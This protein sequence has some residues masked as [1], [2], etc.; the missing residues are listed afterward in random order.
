VTGSTGPQADP[1]GP[2]ATADDAGGGGGGGYP[3][4]GAGGLT[5]GG[6]GGAGIGPT[7]GVG[8][9]GSAGLVTITY[10]VTDTDQCSADGGS[11]VAEPPAGAETK[12]KIV[13]S[14]GNQNAT[15]TAT[16]NG[17]LPPVCK[18]VGGN[19]SPDWVQFGF[20]DPKDGKTWSKH[21]RVT[22]THPTSKNTAQHTLAE[23][24]ICFA[25]PYKFVVKRG[26]KLKHV[27]KNWEGLL[28]HC[29]SNI[30][31]EARRD[32]PGK[33]RPCVTGRSLVQKGDGWVVR[34]GYFVP[35]G[36][37]DPQGRSKRVKKKKKRH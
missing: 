5:S 22:G 7:T 1:P 15:L 9:A 33:A 31:A 30:I 16:L 34:V 35:N 32:H 24:Q 8:A 36:E 28:A 3:G 20:A 37:L 18:S 6:G 10:S 23:T 19:L 11:C 27:G 2:N 29:E 17:G 13:A 4:G 21:I 14:G 26:T 25:A 12:F